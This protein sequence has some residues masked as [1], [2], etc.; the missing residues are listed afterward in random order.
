MREGVDALYAQLGPSKAIRFLQLTGLFKGDS[1]KEL[2]SRSK[3]LTKKQVLK[4]M[5]ESR[6]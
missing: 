3:K 2:E 6:C 1:V 5:D 4:L